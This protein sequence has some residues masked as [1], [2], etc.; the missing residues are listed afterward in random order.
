MNTDDEEHHIMIDRNFG[1]GI[2]FFDPR[3]D[4]WKQN[5]NIDQSACRK[6]NEA[7]RKG[8][9]KIVT[10]EKSHSVAEL[11]EGKEESNAD[12]RN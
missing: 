12:E 6:I 7:M 5:R 11:A 8:N 3:S 10:V 1:S 9:G 4:Y 2:S